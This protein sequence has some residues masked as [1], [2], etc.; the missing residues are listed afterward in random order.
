MRLNASSLITLMV[1]L[2]RAGVISGLDEDDKKKGRDEDNKRGRDKDED[3]D[4]KKIKS[5]C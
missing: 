5:K 3:R 2:L 4:K 1:I